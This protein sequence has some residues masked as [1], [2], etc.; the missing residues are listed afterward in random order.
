MSCEARVVNDVVVIVKAIFTLEEVRRKHEEEKDLVLAE[1][2][3][4]EEVIEWL[5]TKFGKKALQRRL[6]RGAKI[7]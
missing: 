4:R 6:K 3:A 2:D 5:Q 1:K 7:P